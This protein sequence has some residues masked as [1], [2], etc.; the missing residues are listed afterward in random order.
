VEY[1]GIEHEAT[2]RA[3][4]AKLATSRPDFLYDGM[5]LPFEDGSFDTVLSIQVLEHTPHP[6]QLVSEMARVL[7][8][9]GTLILAAPFSFRLHEE[10][11]DYFRYSPHGLR[12][13]CSEAGLAIGHLEQVGSLWTLV[14]HK[15]NSY[16]AL[17]VA[18]IGSVAQDLGKLSHEQRTQVRARLWTLPFVAPAILAISTTARIMDRLFYERQEALGFVVV[19]KRISDS[20]GSLNGQEWFGPSESIRPHQIP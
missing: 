4:A 1:I 19:A 20:L 9:D 12:E 13:L 17:H 16:L 15:L 7:K 18:R 11:H 8:K 3:T 5:R 2:F 14:G 6:R 10:P